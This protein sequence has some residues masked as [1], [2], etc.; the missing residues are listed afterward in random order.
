MTVLE[1]T[2]GQ[3]THATS[4]APNKN[5]NNARYPKMQS[6]A[7]RTFVRFPI[8]QISGRTILSA[9]LSVP[10]KGS[11]ASQDISVA[12][13]TDTWKANTLTWNNQP[14]VGAIETDTFGPLSDGDMLEV[15]VTSFVQLLANGQANYGF[16]IGSNSGTAQALYGFGSGKETSWVLTVETSDAAA[17]PTQLRPAGTISLA[18]WVCDIADVEDLAAIRVQVDPAM[19]EVTPDFDSGWVATTVSQLD[20]AGTAYGG[21]ADFTIT[22]WR[23]A[24][25]NLDGEESEFSGWVQVDRKVK[26][27]LSFTNP[28]AGLLWDSS[29]EITA[30]LSSGVI[31]QWRLSVRSATDSS[32]ILYDT[33]L[34]DGVGTAEIAWQIPES[35]GSWW[36]S[37]V[38]RRDGDYLLSL[39]VW[40]SV[41]RVASIGD[42]AWIDL[43]EVVTLDA[44][45]AVNPPD[46]IVAWE[47]EDGAP[48]ITLRVTRAA[49]PELFEIHR[50]GQRLAPRI[51]EADAQVS[52]GTWELTDRT[53]PPNTLLTYT[54]RVITGAVQSTNSPEV[55]ITNAVVGVWLLSEHGDVVL[56][57]TDT[58]SLVRTDKRA[59][60]NLPGRRDQVDIIS[61]FGGR[62]GSFRGVLD[63]RRGVDIVAALATLEAIKYDPETPVRLVYGQL[64]IP[65]LL[66]NLD[67][68]AHPESLIALGD[69][70]Q[71]VTFECF[72][73]GEFDDD[74]FPAQGRP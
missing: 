10:V 46:T 59:T 31:E 43:N 37:S 66:R 14:A 57:G 27:T 13:P 16:R 29:P 74:G 2:S 56:D 32:K 17:P 58:G 52:A 64:N 45:G 3:D 55:E 20:L 48:G 40:D 21:L 7:A 15:D 22:Y 8:S 9:T 68:D 73:V 65:V 38:F 69:L 19:D 47:T 42:P 51:D 26:P 25:K 44:D 5:E 39:R 53:A 30:E 24:I 4:A 34:Q 1:F 18:K 41:T 61:A 62:G 49:D 50:N 23:A 72:Q 70:R 6:G 71:V 33:G 67:W 63:N 12:M 28:S 60:Y 35:R 36:D 11:F 54:V